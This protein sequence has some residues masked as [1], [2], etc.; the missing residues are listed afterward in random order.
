MASFVSFLMVFCFEFDDI[1]R[2][3]CV[4][5]LWLSSDRSDCLIRLGNS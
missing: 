5:N 1:I 3:G 2:G 4:D